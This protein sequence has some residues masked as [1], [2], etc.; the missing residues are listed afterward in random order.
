M[1]IWKK[2]QPR[3]RHSTSVE[4]GPVLK[5]RVKDWPAEAQEDFK[6]VKNEL[7]KWA[8]AAPGRDREGLG[9]IAYEAVK[10]AYE[11]K[12]DPRE[13]MEVINCETEE[14]LWSA[15]KRFSTT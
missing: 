3:V 1:D 9:L 13:G 2:P 6:R 7:W 14:E 12:P 10:Q 15:L 5:G 11:G 4:S 8:K